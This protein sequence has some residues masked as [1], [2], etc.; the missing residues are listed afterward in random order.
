M[1]Q[2]RGVIATR[3]LKIFAVNFEA[4]LSQYVSLLPNGERAA[5]RE[6]DQNDRQYDR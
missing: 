4:N 3:D 1:H 6:I 5:P 2:Q